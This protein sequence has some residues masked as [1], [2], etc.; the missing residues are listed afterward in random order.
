MLTTKLRKVG[1][2]VMMVV[3]PG[4]LEMLQLR[5]DETVTLAV[6]RKRLIVE[7]PKKPNYTLAELLSQCD[8]KAQFTKEDRKWL[9]SGPV[10][11]ELL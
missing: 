2:S 1:G 11:R 10:G 9:D 4:I 7:V 5:A 3:P 8:A 6:D